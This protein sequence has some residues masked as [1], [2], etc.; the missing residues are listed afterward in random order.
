ASLAA[1]FASLGVDSATS[2]F[3]ADGYNTGRGF[4]RV[5]KTGLR[6][7]TIIAGTVFGLLIVVAGPLAS[8]FGAPDLAGAVR[9]AA[10]ALFFSAGFSWVSGIFEGVQQG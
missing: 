9:A 3:V 2:R 8:A 6:L 4:A 1:V 10:I 5:L 7:R